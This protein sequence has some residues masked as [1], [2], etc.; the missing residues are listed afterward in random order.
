MNTQF[1]NSFQWWMP[2]PWALAAV[3]IAVAVFALRRNRYAVVRFHSVT[4]YGTQSTVEGSE[5]WHLFVEVLSTGSDVFDAR[6]FLECYYQPSQSRYNWPDVLVLEFQPTSSLPNP[7]KN[8]QV[9]RFELTD[10]HLQR[11]LELNG[12]YFCLPSRLPRRRTRLA[13]YTSGERLI[14]TTSSFAFRRFLRLFDSHSAPSVR[15]EDKGGSLYVQ[16][17]IKQ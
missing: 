14:A 13:L 5:V 16:P 8:G 7:I 3:G 10:D 17:P 11:A 4:S 15:T 6:L 9:V 12:G 1:L 2:I